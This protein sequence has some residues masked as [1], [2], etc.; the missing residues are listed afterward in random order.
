LRFLPDRVRSNPAIDDEDKLAILKFQQ[1]CTAEGLSEARILKY[2]HTLMS[3]CRLKEKTFEKMN[4][5]DMIRLVEIVEKRKDWADWTKHDLKVTL[6]KF[7][8]FLRG[9]D[10]RGVYPDE[11]NWIT[12]TMK[13]ANSR[14][15]EEVLTVEEV[16]RLAKTATSSRDKALVNVFYESGARPGELL[17]LKIKDVTFDDLGAVILVSGKTGDR[18]IRLVASA[19]SLADWISSHPQSSDS[20]SYVWP[21]SDRAVAKVFSSLAVRAKINKRVIPYIFRHSRA[22]HLA[23][24]LTEQQLK[25]LMGWTMGSNMAQVYVHLSGRDLDN[26]LLALHGLASEQKRDEQFRVRICPRC[27]ERNSPDASY[28]KRCAFVLDIETLEW[29]NEQMNELIKQPR[30]ANYLRRIIAQTTKK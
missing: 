1:Q 13:N 24:Q 16:E 9:I 8:R 10:R 7:Y 11:V 18:R 6:K 20:A 14:L 21:I 28:C 23:T 27:K 17:N 30:V 19:P 22:T 4:R 12:T 3:I 29:E 2:M 5:D 15:P 26:A 25:Q